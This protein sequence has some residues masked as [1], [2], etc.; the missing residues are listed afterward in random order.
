MTSIDLS[1]FV[2]YELLVDAET[3]KVV[4]AGD[5]EP[6]FSARKL[7]DMKDVIYDQEWLVTQKENFDLYYMYRDLTRAKDKELFKKHD[8]RFDVTIIPPK[9]LGKE[10]VKTAGHFHPEAKNGHSFPEVYE[11]MY[12]KGLYLLQKPK[13]ELTRKEKRAN[14]LNPVEVIVISA[15][16]GDQVMIPPGYGH[17]TI[18]PSEDTTLIMNNLVSSSFNSI[19]EPIKKQQGAIYLY[20]INKTWIRN[21]SYKDDKILVKEGTPEK[22][23]DK[24]FYASF[25][26]NPEQW[27]FLNEPWIKEY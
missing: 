21:P 7:L 9:F 10:Y 3:C 24:P 14:I 1:D 23:V 4:K 27:K 26:E 15:K 25:I 11:V 8:I 5:I 13:K 19:Y 12:G 17:I 22:I 18:N 2:P 16:A 20:H 6:T